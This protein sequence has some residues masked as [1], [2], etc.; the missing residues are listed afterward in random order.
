MSV[1]GNPTEV[2][3]KDINRAINVTGG[4]AGS[5]LVGR[6]LHY[7][8]MQ[9]TDK[10]ISTDMAQKIAKP[11]AKS[12]TKAVLMEVGGLAGDTTF[13]AI[14]M[15][16]N[17]IEFEGRPDLIEK[18]DELDKTSLAIGATGSALTLGA[19]AVYVP[20]GA[21]VGAGFVVGNTIYSFNAE[22]EK[23]KLREEYRRWKTGGGK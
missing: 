6:S 9:L 10:V 2:T 12:A 22:L 19:G 17:R 11:L 21:V 4:V 16:Q 7:E 15:N 18:A 8:G 23:D 5:S 14:N 13:T 20:A 3:S 1:I